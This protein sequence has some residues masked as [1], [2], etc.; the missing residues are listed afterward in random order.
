MQTTNGMW[1]VLSASLVGCASVPAPVSCPPPAPK[2]QILQESR[3]TG[4][5]LIER[6]ESLLEKLR[7]SL[8]KA[9][10]P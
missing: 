9:Q 5:S 8:E 10:R 2:P 6:Y 1:L 7:N 3:S 4:P